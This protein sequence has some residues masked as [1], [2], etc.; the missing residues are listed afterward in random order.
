MSTVMVGGILGLQPGQTLGRYQ[1]L[2]PL[3]EG[4]MAVVYKAQQPS[5][6]RVVA[7]K[8]IRSGFAEDRDFMQRFE[9]EAKAIA[10]LQHPNIVQVHDYDTVDGRPFIAMQYLQGGTLKQRLES[11]ALAGSRLPQR[12]AAAIVGQVAAALDHAHSIDVIHRDVKPSNVMLT[13]DG[14]AVVTDFGI[15]K[16]VGGQTQHTQTGVGIGTPEY[17]SPEQGQGNPIDRR[18]DVYSLAV[19]AYE[20]LTGRI[21]FSADTPLAVVL[22]HMKDPLPRPSSFNADVGPATEGVLMKALAKDPTDRYDSA[23]SFA[24]ALEGAIAKDHPPT[25]KTV[26]S[27]RVAAVPTGPEG[28]WVA[29]AFITRRAMLAT[30]GAAAG[31]IVLGGIAL[32]L[33]GGDGAPPVA[34]G[35]GASAA[36]ATTGAAS[37]ASASPS[38]KPSPTAPAEWGKAPDE[39][40]TRLAHFSSSHLIARVGDI[41]TLGMDVPTAWACDGTAQPVGLNYA[42]V[43]APPNA[44]LIDWSPK[45]FGARKSAK[46]DASP[47]GVKWTFGEQPAIPPNCP[48]GTLAK[49]EP[50]QG[51]RCKAA[52][53]ILK[54]TNR[55][56]T[57]YAS[58]QNQQGDGFAQLPFGVVSD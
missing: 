39:G 6:E 19:V 57:V 23:G 17:M 13:G 42:Q 12:E 21:P 27:P 11:L 4:G 25:A 56:D 44:Q 52:F 46:V 36:P 45:D 33:R 2:E 53:Q 1:I 28:A 7:L 26:V 50:V 38:P 41:V 48:P 40:Q 8:V 5:L 15:A 14:R 22:K 51:I 58:A 9:R 24:A 49:T 47:G 32:A 30:G 34:G 16:M 10:R 29:G 31:L 54:P 20:M 3:G 35:A 43:S 55:W 18:S 37:T